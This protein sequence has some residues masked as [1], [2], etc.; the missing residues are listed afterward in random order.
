MFFETQNNIRKYFSGA[1]AKSEYKERQDGGEKSTTPK[2]MKSQNDKLLSSSDNE[3]IA[4]S[5][6]LTKLSVSSHSSSE[7]HLSISNVKRSKKNR[8]G[9]KNSTS[10]TSSCSDT[11]EEKEIQITADRHHI[12]VK[13]PKFFFS[14]IHQ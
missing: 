11:E 13:Y 7:T 6:D 3:E 9:R 1:K 14:L 2:S 4:D 5:D 8:E 12:F 10:S